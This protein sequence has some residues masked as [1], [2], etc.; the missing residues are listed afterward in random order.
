[1]TTAASK[2]SCSVKLSASPPRPLLSLCIARCQCARRFERGQPPDSKGT[3]GDGKGPVG[4]QP[5]RPPVDQCRPPLSH[6]CVQLLRHILLF[7]EQLSAQCCLQTAGSK[8]NAGHVQKTRLSKATTKM[9]LDIV[10]SLLT[11]LSLVAPCAYFYPKRDRWQNQKVTNGG[12]RG[13][14]RRGEA[15][16]DIYSMRPPTE[17]A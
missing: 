17:A 9:T 1:M 8:A 4:R 7:P 5:R 11:A 16:G 12:R 3:S 2:H 13:L 6:R 10:A 15:F 14:P